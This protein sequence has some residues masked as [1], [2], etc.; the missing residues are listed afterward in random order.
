[1][2]VRRAL[3]LAV[4]RVAILA[5]IRHGVG[6]LQETPFPPGHRLHIDV[7]RVP[8]D[9]AAANRLLDAAGWVRGP[10]GIRQKDGRRLDF[11]FAVGT[12]LTDT[13]QIVELMRASWSQIGARFEV[14]HYPSPLYFA[15][16]AAG[17][18]IYA[19]KYDVAIYAWYTPPNGDVGNLFEC[20]RV[21]PRG[22]NIP[23]WCDRE[24]DRALHDFSVTY[25]DARQRADSR[26]FQLALV[27]DVPT[28]V[29]DAREDVY[30]FNDDLHGFHPNQVTPFDDL[31]DA[32]I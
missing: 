16:A 17:G 9:I 28:I 30:A 20:E 7:P 25:D 15:P 8:Y 31:V 11:D 12:G 27:R 23:R 4:D 3:R 29:L 19:G 1:V 10:D 24:A 32:D 22:Q 6:V 21:P 26:T 14:K 2:K 5:K 13:D 18:I